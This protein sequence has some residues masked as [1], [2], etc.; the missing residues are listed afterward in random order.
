MVSGSCFVL[1]SRLHLI[2][3]DPRLLR[4]ILMIILA[5]SLTIQTPSLVMG[6]FS[7]MIDPSVHRV[8]H[9]ISV[10][11]DTV[12]SV[13]EVCLSTLYLF[14]LIRFM[15][16]GDTPVSQYMITTI[17]LV[18]LVE[19]LN[20]LKHVLMNVLLFLRLYLARRM[21]LGL[22]YAITLR[23]EFVLLARLSN[24]TQGQGRSQDLG[25]TLRWQDST[26]ESYPHSI[27]TNSANMLTCAQSDSPCS[28][29]GIPVAPTL[30]S[31]QSKVQNIEL[32]KET[33]S[34]TSS[35]SKGED[36]IEEV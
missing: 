33:L 14:L 21:V 28:W 26:T 36:C 10:P 1:Y 8:Y 29:L 11:F 32:K 7:G 15:R 25:A 31:D 12:F 20:I 18:V 16:Q 30:K 6:Y 19:A 23:I 13:L 34:N 5:C 27:Q 9:H 35:A 4:V 22:L 17:H 2:L 24:G 3:P